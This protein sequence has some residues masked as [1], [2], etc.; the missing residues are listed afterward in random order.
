MPKHKPKLS[1]IQAE[2][3]E[4]ASLFETEESARTTGQSLVPRTRRWC[5]EPCTV[6]GEVFLVVR[7]WPENEGP[8]GAGRRW[9]KIANPKPRKKPHGEEA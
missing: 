6:K 8:I 4:K 7:H 9:L 3:P 2:V 1:G 5:I